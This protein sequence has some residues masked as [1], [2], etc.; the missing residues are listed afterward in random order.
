MAP[1]Q[2][3]N[4]KGGNTRPYMLL[5][6]ARQQK[7]SNAVVRRKILVQFRIISHQIEVFQIKL[8][9]F[10]SRYEIL[11]DNFGSYVNNVLYHKGNHYFRGVILEAFVS[12]IWRSSTVCLRVHFVINQCFVRFVTVLYFVLPVFPEVFTST[13]LA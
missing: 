5:A 1:K 6:S 12:R 13:V 8:Y 4:K 3:L 7:K 11:R 9:F 2:F 10:C